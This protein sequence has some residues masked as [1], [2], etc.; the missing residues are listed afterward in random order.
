MFAHDIAGWLGVPTGIVIAVMIILRRRGMALRAQ[1]LQAREADQSA[2]G[3]RADGE[4]ASR[5]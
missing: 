1:R 4:A 5:D 2:Q 3:Q